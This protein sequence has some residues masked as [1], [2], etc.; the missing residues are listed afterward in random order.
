MSRP[1]PTAEAPKTPAAP[2]VREF[3][4]VA[5][6]AEKVGLS[7]R[8]VDQCIADGELLCFRPSTRV[9]RI[10]ASELERWIAEFSSRKS[11]A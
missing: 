4:S 6:V 7:R 11:A 8:F 10:R 3:F 1:S 2:S 5:E 9:V